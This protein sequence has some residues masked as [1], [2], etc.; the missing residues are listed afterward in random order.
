M[1]YIAFPAEGDGV[2]VKIKIVRSRTERVSVAVRRPS[3]REF[4]KY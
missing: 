1:L 3:W 2:S 4:L